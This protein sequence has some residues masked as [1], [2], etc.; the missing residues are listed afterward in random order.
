MMTDFDDIARLRQRF[1]I[2]VEK[3]YGR[4]LVYLDNAATSQRPIE[5]IEKWED[6]TLHH[7]ANLHRAVHKLSADAT[8]EYERTRE[9]VRNHINAADCGEVVFTS[10]TT[11]GINLVAYSFGESEIK[12]GDEIIIAECEHHSD[13]VPWQM[14]ARRKGAVIKVLPV[15]E[16]GY[17]DMDRLRGIL[18]S[19]RAKIC[20]VAHVS[21]V[22]GLV[23]PIKEIVSICHSY[24][25]AVLT[26]GA[27]GVVH[28]PVD[29]RE[30]DCDFYVFS[31]HKVYAAPGTGV[32]YGK[33]CWMDKLPPYMGGGE[34]IDTVK[35]EGTS[36]APSP[37]KFEAGT[38]NIAGT[39]TLIPALEYV[40]G[41]RDSAI[42]SEQRKIVDYVLAAFAD[43]RRIRLFGRPRQVEDKLPLFSIAVEGAHHEDLAQLLD[44]MGIAVRSG[45]MCAGP[46]MD[47]Y[48]VS[49]MLR[50][51]FAP[52]NTMEEARCFVECLHRAIDMLV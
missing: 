32:M 9:Y 4:P 13:I 15:D 31:G 39:P 44:K 2:L 51:S 41:L 10:G 1:P 6:I 30:L 5:V 37:Q 33:K 12:E 26:D 42:E 49:G 22:L 21:N 45:Q 47:R 34:M 38:Q 36:F 11:A 7:N 28:C 19:G 48:G 40:K 50:A 3:V 16:D 29:V 20:C 14:M 43:D 23:N 8:E 27:Q 24:G 46:L 17:P 18:S 35:W 52:Y 25:C